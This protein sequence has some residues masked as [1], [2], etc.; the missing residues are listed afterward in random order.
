MVWI[1]PKSANFIVYRVRDYTKNMKEKTRKHK[2]V[3]LLTIF[4]RTIR[5]KVT[6]WMTV[7]TFNAGLLSREY[8]IN[9]KQF[10]VNL[11]HFHFSFVIWFSIKITS[12]SK[13]W[14]VS[15][16]RRLQSL[17]DGIQ[18][19]QKL[20]KQWYNEHL[21]CSLF[22]LVSCSPVRPVWMYTI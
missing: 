17:I 13:R 18:R 2:K 3:I 11:F 10:T 16:S 7:S 6:L 15:R 12:R 5:I 1:E 19:K 4:Q 8:G 9:N 22:G 21:H 14:L 20:I